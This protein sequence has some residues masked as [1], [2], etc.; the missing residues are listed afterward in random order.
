MT[1]KLLISNLVVSIE[2]YMC[3][4]FLPPFTYNPLAI[5]LYMWSVIIQSRNYS[6]KTWYCLSELIHT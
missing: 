2:A 6:K 4:I 3:S 1:T 5:S